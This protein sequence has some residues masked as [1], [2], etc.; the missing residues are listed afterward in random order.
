MGPGRGL[1]TVIIQVVGSSAGQPACRPKRAVSA[2]ESGYSVDVLAGRNHDMACKGKWHASTHSVTHFAHRLAWPRKSVHSPFIISLFFTMSLFPVT[3][4]DFMQQRQQGTVSAQAW[5]EDCLARAESS[6]AAHVFTKLYPEAARLAARHADDLHAAGL[7]AGPLAGAP[8][9]IKDLYDVAGETTTAGTTLFAGDAPARQDAP[10][11]ARLRA[12]GAAIVGKTNMT[13]LAFSGIGINPHYGT[14]VNPA[15]TQVQRIPGGSSSG[16]AVSV[17]LGL[18]VAGLGSDTGGS[19]RIP[20]AL[21]GLVG[22]K[23]T[24]SRVPLSG[25]VPL[26]HSLDTV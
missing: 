16:A 14:P 7:A 15:D 4:S 12:A 26:S 5:V 25:A 22:F 9:T 13:E 1:R 21:C 2:V 10:A 20:A 18:A 6:A 23:S 17:A 24:Q 11:V 19:I 8:V 3:L